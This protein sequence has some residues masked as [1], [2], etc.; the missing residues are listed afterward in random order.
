MCKFINHSKDPFRRLAQYSKELIVPQKYLSIVPDR[1]VYGFGPRMYD[2]S[3]IREQPAVA[4]RHLFN[5][6][7]GYDAN[8]W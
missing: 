3:W 7:L 2:I 8:A 4:T 1:N 6:K 5:E